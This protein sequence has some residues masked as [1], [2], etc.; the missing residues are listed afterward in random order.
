MDNAA[1]LAFAVSFA[2]HA[3]AKLNGIEILYGQAGDT[4]N[5]KVLDSTTGTYTTVPN[6]LLNQFGFDWNIVAGAQKELLPYDADILVD[7]QIVVEYTNNGNS[8][9]EVGVNF[10]IHEDKS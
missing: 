7:M 6:Y 1:D 3:K 9:V 8:D 5:L 10:Y 2:T 4:C